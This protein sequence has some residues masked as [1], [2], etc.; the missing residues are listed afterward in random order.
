MCSPLTLLV[1]RSERFFVPDPMQIPMEDGSSSRHCASGTLAVLLQEQF[2]GC[3]MSETS[4]G[5]VSYARWS[6][7]KRE[8]RKTEQRKCPCRRFSLAQDAS[9][10]HASSSYL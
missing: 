4:R 8:S 10:S 3:L 5:Y 2:V 7:W 9:I 6:R 1:Y